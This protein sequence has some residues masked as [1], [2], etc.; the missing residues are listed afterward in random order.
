MKEGAFD[1]LVMLGNGWPAAPSLGDKGPQG[2]LWELYL[3]PDL[4]AARERQE[5]A[6]S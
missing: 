3:C 5:A 6:E 1:A 2:N 4:N